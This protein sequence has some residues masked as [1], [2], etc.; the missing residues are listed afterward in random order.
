M[1]PFGI[2]FQTKNAA[3]QHK[4]MTTEDQI[5]REKKFWAML[6]DAGI[7]DAIVISPPEGGGNTASI[8]RDGSLT[9]IDKRD[10]KR[11]KIK[12]G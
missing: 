4:R 3:S 5:A 2:H 1:M 8:E 6:A 7:V 9:M 11:K 10:G 12:I